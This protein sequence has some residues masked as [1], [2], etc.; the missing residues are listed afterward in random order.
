VMSRLDEL[1]ELEAAIITRGEEKP[2]MH[3]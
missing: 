3:S 1:A 2:R